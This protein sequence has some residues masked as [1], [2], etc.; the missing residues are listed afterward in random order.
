MQ[1]PLKA[2]VINNKRFTSED[3]KEINAAIEEINKHTEIY[4]DQST[5][6]RKKLD[7]PLVHVFYIHCPLVSIQNDSS[8]QFNVTEIE[9]RMLGN[10]SKM[11]ARI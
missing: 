11:M 7:W 3:K 5:G 8:L 2:Y 9:S 10:Y 1:R 6:N 4:R